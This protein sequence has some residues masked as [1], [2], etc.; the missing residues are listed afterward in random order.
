MKF[1]VIMTLVMG[2]KVDNLQY[3]LMKNSRK[4][5]TEAKKHKT[6]DKAS[7]TQTD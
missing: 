5:M 3:Q 4:C 6:M 1:S 7:C 2:L